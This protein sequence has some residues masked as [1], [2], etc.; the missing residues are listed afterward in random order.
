MSKINDYFEIFAFFP[1]YYYSRFSCVP[2]SPMFYWNKKRKMV[3]VGSTD[4]FA[5]VRLH[6]S[7]TYGMRRISFIAKKNAEEYHK[8]VENQTGHREGLEHT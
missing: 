2:E 5:A 3:I 4:N 8:T 7:S 1:Q 6:G